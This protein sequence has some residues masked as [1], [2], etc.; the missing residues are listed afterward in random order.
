MGINLWYD[1]KY[2]KGV[3]IPNNLWLRR[4][5]R[6]WSIVATV[7]KKRIWGN[8]RYIVVSIK[9]QLKFKRKIV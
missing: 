2:R 9:V 7:K 6:I 8:L 1:D 4:K 3:I 5:P